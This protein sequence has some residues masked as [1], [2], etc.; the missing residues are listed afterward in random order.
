MAYSITVKDQ[1]EFEQRIKDKDLAISKGI[2]TG[3]LQNLVG[4]KKHIYVLEVYVKSEDSIVDITV[5]RDDFIS[6]LEENLKTHIYHE[7]YESCAG[8]SQAID[9]LKG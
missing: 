1:E 3:I 2:V 5:H 8:I 7:D 4:K 9:F 6:T